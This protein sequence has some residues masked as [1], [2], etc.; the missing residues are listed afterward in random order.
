MNSKCFRCGRYGHFVS[1]CFATYHVRGNKLPSFGEEED[2]DPYVCN[3]CGRFGHEEGQCFAR[4]TFD[5]KALPPPSSE[6]RLCMDDSS[7][8]SD[9]YH[10]PDQLCEVD[11]PSIWKHGGSITCHRC[12][13][14]GHST[15]ECYAR[16]TA[17]GH[18]IPTLETMEEDSWSTEDSSDRDLMESLEVLASQEIRLASPQIQNS[19]LHPAEIDLPYSPLEPSILHNV[20][21]GSGEQGRPFT[22][23]RSGVYVL[24]LLNNKWYVGKSIGIYWRIRDHRDGNGSAWCHRHKVLEQVRPI[25]PLADDLEEWERKETLARM[26]AHGLSNVRGWRYTTVNLPKTD[27]M[28]QN[29]TFVNDMTFAESADA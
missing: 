27:E 29:G 11:I 7:P 23:G 13:R 20:A 16:T 15:S 2:D 12:Y 24:R 25:T 5:G 4:T 19:N 3:R 10:T 9:G 28:Q 21:P 17:D 22:W 6:R 26:Y 18:P 1:D 8:E 14:T